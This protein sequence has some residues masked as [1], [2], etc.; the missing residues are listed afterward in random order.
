MTARRQVRWTLTWAVV[1]SALPLAVYALGR[2]SGAI[3]ARE[4][5][6]AAH[7][8]WHRT[9]AGAVLVLS[10]VPPFVVSVVAL[11]A[12]LLAALRTRSLAVLAYAWA[13]AA[14]AAAALAFA[15]R[16][17]IWAVR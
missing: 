5:W 3:P 13:L 6:A 1:L 8:P 10:C 14:F 12:G 16:V 9:F 4:S 7:G 11:V 17:A 15:W 2:L